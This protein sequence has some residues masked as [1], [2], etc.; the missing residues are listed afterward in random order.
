MNTIDNWSKNFD[1]Q[2]LKEMYDSQW[3]PRNSYNNLMI[4]HF[5]MN[6]NSKPNLITLLKENTHW[7]LRHLMLPFCIL[8]SEN[9]PDQN[10]LEV[11]SVSHNHWNTKLVLYKEID[12]TNRIFKFIYSNA[13][14]TDLKHN[15]RTIYL[16]SIIIKICTLYQWSFFSLH[17]WLWDKPNSLLGTKTDPWCYF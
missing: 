5:P 4:N 8:R 10:G 17:G 1:W 3:K 12:E 7:I 16:Q 9:W 2:L 6:L 15:T 14:K 13:I 11:T